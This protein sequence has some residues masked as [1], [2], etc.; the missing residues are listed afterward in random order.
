MVQYHVAGVLIAIGVVLWMITMLVNRA[1]GFRPGGS[2]TWRRSA[3][4]GLWTTI[5]PGS[6]MLL[7]AARSAG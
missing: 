3:A 6:A 7:D 2:R 4:R 1:Q 5:N